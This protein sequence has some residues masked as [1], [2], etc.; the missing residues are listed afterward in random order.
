[1]ADPR[2]ILGLPQGGRLDERKPLVSN[3]LET[4]HNML[5]ISNV[6][7]LDQRGLDLAQGYGDYDPSDAE[8]MDAQLE[9]GSGM[10][11]EALRTGTM[12]HIKQKLAQQGQQQAYKM[13]LAHEKTAAEAQARA[14]QN[15][16]ILARQREL[17]DERANQAA[18]TR[19]DNQQFQSGQQAERLA[20]QELLAGQRQAAGS[21][22]TMVPADMDK[23]LS[24]T[25]KT[26]QGSHPVDY[27]LDKL[28]GGGMLSGTQG[29]RQDY[30]NSLVSVLTRQ[31]SMQDLQAAVQ[32]LAQYPGG[33]QDKLAAA[34]ADP[35]FEFDLSGLDPYEQEY[36]KLKLGQ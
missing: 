3:P 13:D 5:S 24:D 32:G 19:E 23:R 34:D 15:E 7:K 17:A 29:R 20:Q 8:L 27:L 35:N 28:P 25:R 31:G 14:A 18:L 10:S 36:M 9:T 6:G 22:N 33:L 16:A 21:R 1:M 2:T 26:Y 11:R 4:L 30:E 12:S